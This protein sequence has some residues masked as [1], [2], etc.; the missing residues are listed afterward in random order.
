METVKAFVAILLSPLIFSLLLQIIGWLAIWKQKKPAGLVL[1]GL[2]TLVLTVGS[3]SGLTHDANRRLEYTYEPLDLATMEVQPGV[4]I[5][6]VV[7]GTG[8]NDDPTMP[9]N[10]QVSGV[11]LSR[12]LEGTR[13]HR[14]TSDSQLLVSVAG[15]ASEESKAR[16]L[17]RIVDLL[18]IDAT[19]VGLITSAE[20]TVDEA[21]EVRQ[22][23]ADHHIVLVTSANHMKRAMEIF[24]E[25][26]LSPMA[27]PTGYYFARQGT[28]GDASWPLWIPSTDGIGSNHQWLYE[29]VAML[30]HRVSGR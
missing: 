10:S 7:L 15:D 27:A 30:W 25:V 19:R 28:S 3:L 23:F 26:G 20:S 17:S 18:A 5:V 14:S 22:K 1:L 6:V 24:S 8:F 12:L 21:R 13:I 16:F 29:N 4:P 11:F 9:A 2:A